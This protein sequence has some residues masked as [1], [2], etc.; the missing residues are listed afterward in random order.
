MEKRLRTLAIIAGG[1]FL[2]ILVL[3]GYFSWLNIALVDTMH[4][5]I[6]CPLVQ[7]RAPGLGQVR[8]LALEI[9]DAVAKDEE[10]ATLEVWSSGTSGAPARLLLPV[11]AP[12]AG[13][14]VDKETQSGDV[15]AQGQVLVTLADLDTL[16]VTANIHQTRISQVRIGQP[17]RIR[18]RSRT[19]RRNFWGHVEQIGGAT[20]TA[21]TSAGGAADASMARAGE[22]QVRISI[23]PQGYPLYPGMM[24]E[25]RIK[26]DPR[27]LG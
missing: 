12:I 25:V 3:V 5:R 16:W 7:V 2:I 19:L 20:H 9:G 11:R 15:V 23:D 6:E 8:D 10:L 22:V 1:A 17:V 13:I 24:V 27:S 18:V 4:A 14:V 26:L 21:L